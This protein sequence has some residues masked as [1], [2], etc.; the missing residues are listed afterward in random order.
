MNIIQ[1]EYE[2]EW[3]TSLVILYFGLSLAHPDL[4]FQM[5]AYQ[6]SIGFF[7]ES[8]L[9]A[10]LLIIGLISILALKI[11][12]D[13]PTITAPIRLAMSVTRLTVYIIFTL[14]FINSAY[15][16]EP[17]STAAAT[18][19]IISWFE[20]KITRRLWHGLKLVRK[21]IQCIKR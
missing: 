5:A 3:L 14:S 16:T 9:S 6:N 1:P 18:Y 17:V 4:T 21:S 8:L 7:S 19:G 11:N 2:T 10:S 15:N 20:Y 13:L 12:G